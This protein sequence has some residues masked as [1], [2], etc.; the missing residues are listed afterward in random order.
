L[1]FFVETELNDELLLFSFDFNVLDLL[2][3]VD[4][5]F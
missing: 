4:G 3:A 1:D 2:F 5:D